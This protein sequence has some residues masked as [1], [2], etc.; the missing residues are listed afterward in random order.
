MTMKWRFSRLSQEDD[1]TIRV[2]LKILI[3][4]LNMALSLAADG[5]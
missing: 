4:Q 3:W 5:N 2:K 1:M